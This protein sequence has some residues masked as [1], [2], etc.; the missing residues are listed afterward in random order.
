LCRGPHD[1]QKNVIMYVVYEKE[2]WIW[3]QVNLTNGVFDNM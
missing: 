2:V 1:M 3:L